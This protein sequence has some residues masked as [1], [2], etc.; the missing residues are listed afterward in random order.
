VSVLASCI[1]CRIVGRQAPAEVVVEDER[2]L[3]FLDIHPAGDGHTLVIPKAHANDIWDLDEH[4]GDA[5][6]RVSRRLA[7]A[8]RSAF[9]P[10]GL[11]VR[12]A[13]G[14]AAGQEVM[15]FHLHLIPRGGTSG[16]SLGEV[17]ERL[18]A[19]L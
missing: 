4:D 12:Q 6:W 19:A 18:R 15:H 3:A 10:P 16:L 13:N 7:A 17:A 14:R 9:D 2:V 1:F 5:V 8:I 11:Y